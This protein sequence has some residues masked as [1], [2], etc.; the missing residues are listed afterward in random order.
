V[1]KFGTDGVRGVALTELTPELVRALGRAAAST[2]GPARCAIARDTRESGPV[3]EA[4]LAEGLA[5]GGVDVVLLGVAPTPAAAWLSAADGVMGAVISASHNPYGDNGV[6]LFVPGGRKLTDPEEDSLEAELHRLVEGGAPAPAEP[7]AIS[8]DPSGVGRWEASVVASIGGRR[9]DGLR[10][11]VD[12][13]HGAATAAAPAILT[14][15]GAEVEVL[16]A[17]PDG[18]NINAGCGSTHPDDLQATVVARGADAGIALDGDADRALAVD[19]RGRLVDGDQIMAITAV[20]RHGRGA[21]AGDAV[22]VTVMTNLGFHLGMAAHGI[23]VVQVPVGDRHVLAALA[24]RGLSLGGEQSGHL[25]F[26]DLATTGDGLLTAV[27]LLDVVAHTGRPLAELADEAMTRL[28]QV[29]RNVVVHRP[30][31]E[32]VAELD[33]AVVAAAAELGEQGRV[34]LRPSG[35]EKLVRVMVEA[36]TQEQAEAVAERLA[37]EEP[38]ALFVTPLRRT[39]E[40]AAPLAARTGLEPVV[41]PKLT[42]VGLGEWDGGEMRI[43]A[44]HGDPL[45]FRVIEEERWDV[46]PGAEPMEEFAAR[47]ARGLDAV[48]ERAGPDASVVAVVHGGVIGELCHQATA[49]RPFAFVH[50]DNTSISRLVALPDGRRL[51]RSFNDTAHLVRVEAP[52]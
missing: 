45:F 42:E 23:E 30:G 5:A 15:L 31:A 6:K 2:L 43:R 46:I 36:P 41:V 25:V 3:L 10:V 29:L 51:L 37:A 11:V 9:L 26:A 27:Q 44:A 32:V 14:A 47:V 39:Q 38:A 52:A 28:P 8:D 19:G 12:A 24:E 18:R 33:R 20:D 16:H 50:A 49:S 35:T 17:A 21:L 40:S 4:A 48:V 22:V 7:G 13:A 34:L 1:L